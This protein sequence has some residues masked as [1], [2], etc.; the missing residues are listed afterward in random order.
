[1]I[2]DRRL[3]QSASGGNETVQ[4]RIGVSQVENGR[5][6]DA[7]GDEIFPDIAQSDLQDNRS[8]DILG[9]VRVELSDEQTL[10]LMANFTNQASKVTAGFT[11]QTWRLLRLIL[12]MPISVTALPPTATRAPTARCSA[13]T[14]IMPIC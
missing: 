11:I 5:Q 4:G 10:M 9:N 3:S 14:T 1:M 13:S 6:Y 2:F 7:H 12:T 8:L